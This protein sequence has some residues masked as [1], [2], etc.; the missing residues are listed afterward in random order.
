MFFL[1]PPYIWRVLEDF[2]YDCRTDTAFREHD[3]W[4][5]YNASSIGD[6]ALIT[7]RAP[8]TFPRDGFALPRDGF[9]PP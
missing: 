3:N 9:P 6:N 1:G 7:G 5:Y 8:T 2:D 4:K